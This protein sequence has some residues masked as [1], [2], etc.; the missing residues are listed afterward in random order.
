[1]ENKHWVKEKGKHAGVGWG[2]HLP[3]A[4]LR[5]RRLPNVRGPDSAPEAVC[6]H[7]ATEACIVPHRWWRPTPYSHFLFC[8]LIHGLN[9]K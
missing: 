2:A 9:M 6:K 7:C 4:T 3:V 8:F 1:M 5:T